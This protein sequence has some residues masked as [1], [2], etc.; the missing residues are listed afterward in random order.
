LIDP[1]FEYE[2][3]PNHTMKLIEL[4]HKIMTQEFVV[5]KMVSD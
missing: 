1:V 5:M 4:F 3:T 2:K